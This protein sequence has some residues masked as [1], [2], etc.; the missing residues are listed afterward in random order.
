MQTSNDADKPRRPRK[1][2]LA[3]VAREANVSVSAASKALNHS[4]RISAETQRAVR[5][6]AD[7]LGYQRPADR[8]GASSGSGRAVRASRS[9][10]VGLITSDYNG[11]FSLPLL[12]GAETT[13]GASNHAALL[14]SSHGRPALEKSHIDRLAAYGV[15]G[16]IV[17]G[18]TSNPRPPLDERTTMGLPVVYTYDPSRD[19][20]DCSI[21]CDNIGAGTQAIEYLLSLGRRHIAVVAGSE[22]FQA[23][24]DRVRGAR[25]A[26]GLYDFQPVGVLFDAWSEDWGERAARMLVD[27][28]PDLDAIYCLSDEIARGAVRG[29][30]TIGRRVPDDVAV[31][32]HDNWFVFSTN[33]HPTLT[34]FDNNI[35][36]IGKTAAK[37]LIDAINGRPH[38]G[39]TSVECPMIVRESTEVGRRT[40]LEG[41]ERI[42][43]SRGGV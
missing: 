30:M 1:V 32:G 40:P 25:L 34:T 31:I 38:H 6:A 41:S 28:H 37:F 3:D 15:D 27:R 12:T 20:E 24:R 23:A 16:L 8:A 4:D 33:V 5:M 7:R 42:F 36:L 2:T 22:D 14:M 11:R 17:V 10:L 9:G 35:S 21:I 13:L 39:V 18:D 19:P 43:L 26:F 29:L